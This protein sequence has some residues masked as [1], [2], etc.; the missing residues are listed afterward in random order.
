MLVSGHGFSRAERGS[1]LT[2]ALAPEKSDV[3][4][5]KALMLGA[6]GLGT[7]ESRALT[8]PS[9]IYA[10]RRMP[11]RTVSQQRLTPNQ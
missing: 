2:W 8:Q 9:A 5:A 3:T 6:V 10:D 4:G 7:T 1:W 11:R